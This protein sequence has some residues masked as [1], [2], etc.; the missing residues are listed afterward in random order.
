M[1]TFKQP[2]TKEQLKGFKKDVLI[3]MIL[4]LSGQINDMNEKLDLLTEQ[5]NVFTNNQFGR[6]SE[7]GSVLE[8]ILGPF[9][10]EAEVIVEES[11]EEEL[12]EPSAEDIHPKERAS[13]PKGSRKNLLAELE[14]KDIPLELTGDDLIC[15]NCGNELKYLG[16]E[17]TQR[18]QFQPASFVLENYY[19]YSY[20]CV[21]CGNIVSAD[22]P[23]TLFE[24]SLATP[25]LLAGIAT[26]KFTNA[27]PFDRMERSFQDLDVTLHKQTMARWMI[28]IANEYF[29]LIYERMKEELLSNSIIHAD[30]TTVVVSKDG[31]KAGAKSYMWVYTDEK[32]THPVVIYEYQKTRASKHPKTFLEFFEGW[33]CTDGYD[34]YHSLNDSITVCGC[35]VHCRRYFSD[36]AKALKDLPHRSGEMTIAEEAI[37]RIAE[38][39][40]LDNSWVDLSYDERMELRNT[41]LK[42]KMIDYFDWIE[43]VKGHAPPKSKTG[44]GITYSLN[45]KQY[46][47]GVLTN[48]DVPLDNSEAERKIRNFVVSRKNFVLIDTMAGAEASAIM[49]SMSETLKANGLKA[50]E[51]F[52]YVLT[53][54]PKYMGKNFKDP[55][56]VDDFLPWSDKLPPEVRKTIKK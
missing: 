14:Q 42:E 28:R 55:S 24:G 32:G 41:E 3:D 33:L 27:M 1:S 35:W 36:A 29:A 6:Q 44:K 40:H 53:E 2:L 19:I 37:R 10:N 11:T 9:F 52:K 34:G 46:L 48:P 25:S 8:S 13:H 20:K 30:E 56:F 49:F 43:S 4:A 5:I 17:L 21:K 18:L 50:H 23:L 22:R 7:Q 45:Q 51:Y 31:R 15:G 16:K 26:A 47:L 54:M 39:F 38:F 12:Q